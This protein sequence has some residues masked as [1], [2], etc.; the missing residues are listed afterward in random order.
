MNA[1]YNCEELATSSGKAHFFFLPGYDTLGWT[2]KNGYMDM[3][4]VPRAKEYEYYHGYEGGGRFQPH[5]LTLIVSG[6]EAR[7]LYKSPEVDVGTPQYNIRQ[8]TRWQSAQV[9][10]LQGYA[11][12]RIGAFTYAHQL[13]ITSFNVT[14]LSD[15]ANLPTAYC[16]AA[17]GAFCDAGV[18]GLCLAVAASGVCEGAVDPDVYDTTDVEAFD[19]VD[20]DF[21]GSE[22]AWGIGPNGVL[23]QSSNAN[24][25]DGTMLGCNALAGNVS[26]TDFVLEV[27][28]SNQDN[29]GV[30]LNFGW[31]GPDDQYVS[32]SYV[33]CSKERCS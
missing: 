17:P 24:R 6:Q 4:T 7:L 20:D 25:Y 32:D 3:D 26:Y 9:F 31:K 8:A 16:G 18:T 21:L 19:Y 27:W 28:M 14:D 33:P 1:S 15:P 10:D 23:R 2:S 29:D 22:C 12:G 5:K 13:N 30:G 11:G